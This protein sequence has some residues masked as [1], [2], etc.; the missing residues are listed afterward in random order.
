MCLLMD[1]VASELEALYNALC[2]LLDGLP[3]VRLVGFPGQLPQ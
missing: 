3:G 2:A 1:E